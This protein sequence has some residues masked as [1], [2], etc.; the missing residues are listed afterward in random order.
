M[1]SGSF[2]PKIV[3]KN[4]TSRPGVYRMLGKEELVLYVG[5]AKNLKRRVSSYFNRSNNLRIQTMVS[6]IENIE[7][8]V[9]HT[10]VEKVSPIII[11]LFDGI[12]EVNASLSICSGVILFT[13]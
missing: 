4:L 5:K 12:I 6:Q 8:T 13:I 2:D 11:C 3:Q 9:T 7:V 1:T 10:E